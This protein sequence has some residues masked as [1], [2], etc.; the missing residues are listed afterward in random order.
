MLR[1]LNAE[2]PMAP[3]FRYKEFIRSA[4]ALRLGIR[5][6]PNEREWQS[7]E[8]VAEHIIQPIRNYFGQIRITSG[9]RSVELCRNIGSSTKSNHTRGEAID[10]EPVD[11]RIKLIDI[12]KWINVNL[13]Y[14]EMIAEYLPN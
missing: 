7:V 6:I 9:F 14:R 12:V 3:N 8:R 4:T 5:N 11:P 13:D 2:L 1:D 10:F